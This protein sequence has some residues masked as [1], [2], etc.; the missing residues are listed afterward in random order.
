MRDV[1]EFFSFLFFPQQ[2]P[3]SVVDILIFLMFTRVPEA[4]VCVSLN[5]TPVTDPILCCSGTGSDRFSRILR[6][7]LSQRRWVGGPKSSCSTSD[8]IGATLLASVFLF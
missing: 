4:F 7:M 3:V 8:G 6:H 2:T 1:S 5:P